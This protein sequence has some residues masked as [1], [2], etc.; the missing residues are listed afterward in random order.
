MKKVENYKSKIVKKLKLYIK[1]NKKII[2]FDNTKIEEYE[3][4]QY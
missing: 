3:C 2:E 1:M 4:H